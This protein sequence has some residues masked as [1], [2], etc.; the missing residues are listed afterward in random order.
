MQV[1][2]GTMR[3]D[4]SAPLPVRQ[5]RARQIGRSAKQLGELRGKRL[6]YNLRSLAGR[7]RIIAFR[8][9]GQPALCPFGEIIRQLPRD[10]AAK[11]GS[12]RGVHRLVSRKAPPPAVLCPLPRRARVPGRTQLRWHLK[13]WIGPCER[14]ARGARLLGAE[15]RAMDVVRAR[16]PGGT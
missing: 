12:E 15:R 5:V 4:R 16:H 8:D 2:A 1:V 10:T 9:L 3:L 6:D 14:D 11:L 7:D 13:G